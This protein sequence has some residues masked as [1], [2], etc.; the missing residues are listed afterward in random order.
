[1]RLGD[2]DHYHSQMVTM[3]VVCLPERDAV[4]LEIRHVSKWSVVVRPNEPKL[5]RTD[6][7]ACEGGDTSL[8]RLQ[9]DRNRLPNESSEVNQPI[10]SL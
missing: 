6:G 8:F 2:S 10:W 7:F 4:C 9:Q 1:M 5:S 3:F